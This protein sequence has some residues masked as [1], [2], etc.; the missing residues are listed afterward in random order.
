[1]GLPEPIDEALVLE[2]KHGRLVEHQ[3]E[4]AVFI[5][6]LLDE[7][8]AEGP[9]ELAAMVGGTYDLDI[10]DIAR[11]ADDVIAETGII[12]PPR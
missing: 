7:S 8:G 3:H 10:E 1:L 5:M 9:E 6:R 4:L 12:F 2:E 11:L